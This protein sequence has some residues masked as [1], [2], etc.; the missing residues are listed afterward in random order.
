[1]EVDELSNLIQTLKAEVSDWMGQRSS[2]I[3]T[4]ADVS[5]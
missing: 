2:V 5:F 4:I 3:T 1:M